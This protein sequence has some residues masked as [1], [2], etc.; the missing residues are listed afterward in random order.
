MTDLDLASA[1]VKR[2]GIDAALYSSPPFVILNELPAET[3]AAW[4]RIFNDALAATLQGQAGAYGLAMVPLQDP[5]AAAA[6]LRR[7]VR[8]LGFRGVE[9]PSNINGVELDD[10]RL[11]PFWAAAQE[12]DAPVLIHPH[13]VAGGNRMKEYYLQEPDRQSPG[14]HAGRGAAGASAASLTV[15][16]GSRSACRTPAATLWRAWGAWTTATASTPRPAA[17]ASGR[18][19]ATCTN[20]YFDTIAHSAAW[21]RFVVEQRGRGARAAGH[22]PAL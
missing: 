16:R 2:M 18:P 14:H 21:L 11:D 6:E 4:S 10:A 19:A 3:G 17:R 1:E 9:I 7:A 8:E 5:P 15:S 13:Y 22:R 20:L 12:L